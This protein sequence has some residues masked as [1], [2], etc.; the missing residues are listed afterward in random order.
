MAPRA[1]LSWNICEKGP[2]TRD[3][4]LERMTGIE[5]ALSAWEA[6]VLPLNYIRR[7]CTAYRLRS[8]ADADLTLPR[9]EIAWVQEG[10][11]AVRESSGPTHLRPHSAAVGPLRSS[12]ACS[13]KSTGPMGDSARTSPS[14]RHVVVATAERSQ[15]CRAAGH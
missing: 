4:S 9:P 1:S 8:L 11:G 12:P 10:L 2:L 13:A 3:D 15:P 7:R 5:P 14:A 6:D